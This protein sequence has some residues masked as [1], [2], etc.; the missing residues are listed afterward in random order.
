MF[1]HHR[2]TRS[3]TLASVASWGGTAAVVAPAQGNGHSQVPSLSSTGRY[4]AFESL[5]KNLV[6][7]DTNSV[8]DVFLRDLGGVNTTEP[9]SLSETC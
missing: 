6:L 5:A 7:R 8:F 2:L 1:V 9:I 3:T 4:V